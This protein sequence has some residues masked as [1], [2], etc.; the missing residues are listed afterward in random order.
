MHAPRV[1]GVYHLHTY[2]CRHARGDAVHYA[3]EARAAG[4]QRIGVADHT[5]LPDGRWPTVR[6]QLAELA[7]YEAAV[8]SARAAVP[9][10]E[11]LLGMECEIEPA[12]FGWYRDTFL[13]RGYNYLIGSVH[14]VTVGDEELSAFGACRSVEALVQWV[15]RIRQACESGLFA[16][17]AH[18]DNIACG[19]PAAWTPEV[20]A[21]TREVC[22]IA[23]AHGMPLELNALGLME[24]RGYPWRPFWELAAEAGCHAVLSTDAHRP[25]HTARGLSQIAD[26][27]AELGLRVVEP[28]TADRR[29]PDGAGP[30]PHP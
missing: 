17:I 20:A 25:Q 18:P 28:L 3:Q 19:D 10:L 16:F 11:I 21:A 8:E 9:E 1:R 13:A 5:P 6:M 14:F 27:A 7:D 2:R 26:L 12:Y 24:G 15:Q 23:A 4:L 22:A 30:R 29:G